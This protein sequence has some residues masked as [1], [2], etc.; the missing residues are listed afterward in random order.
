[1][2]TT[3]IL[4]ICAVVAALCVVGILVR[5]FKTNDSRKSEDNPAFSAEILAEA[6]DFL[7]LRDEKGKI[8][9]VE[10]KLTTDKLGDKIIV[11]PASEKETIGVFPMES[12]MLL[13]IAMAG[14]LHQAL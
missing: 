3:I 6:G 2:E 5:K 11:C 13:L 14:Y 8:W 1:M 4:I 12:R 10:K 9:R 7:I